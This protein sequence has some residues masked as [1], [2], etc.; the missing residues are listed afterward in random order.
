MDW[1][2]T[3]ANNYNDRFNKAKVEQDRLD[4]LKK[5]VPDRINEVWNWYHEVHNEINDK[6]NGPA[7]FYADHK[8]LKGEIAGTKY[9]ADV[10]TNR[11]DFGSIFFYFSKNGES[12]KTSLSEP[13]NNIFLK[14]SNNELRWVF[15]KGKE[16]VLFSKEHVE[17]LFKEILSDYL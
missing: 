13:T 9:Y 17:E 14:E 2:D 4:D 12:A 16:Q 8:K 11:E 5:Q 10:T 6:L 15:N 7:N 3:I 1:K